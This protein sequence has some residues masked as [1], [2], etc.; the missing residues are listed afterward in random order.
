MRENTRKDSSSSDD[1]DFKEA[2]D[3]FSK[4]LNVDQ[5]LGRIDDER[6]TSNPG[7]LKDYLD[8]GLRKKM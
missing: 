7:N 4:E 1:E 2:R 3:R 5:E 6:V 8:F